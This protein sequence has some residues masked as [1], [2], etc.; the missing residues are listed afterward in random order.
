MPTGK[1]T[2]K[3][4]LSRND[5]LIISPFLFFVLF[6]LFIIIIIT[7]VLSWIVLFGFFF[8]SHASTEIMA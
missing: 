6:Y 2:K 5:D 7:I 1:E 3:V 8:Y 4:E